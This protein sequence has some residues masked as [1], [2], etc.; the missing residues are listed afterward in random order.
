MENLSN[1]IMNILHSQVFPF[2]VTFIIVGF[3]VSGL[4]MMS[5]RRARDWAKEH[6]GSVILGSVLVYTA[7][8]L[9]QTVASSFGW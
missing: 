6:L 3:V 1:S 7:V 5:G 9:G 2:V 4:A 8:S